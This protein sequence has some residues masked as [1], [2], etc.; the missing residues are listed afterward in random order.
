ERRHQPPRQLPLHQKPG[1]GEGIAE[2]DQTS[3]QAMEKFPKINGFELAQG[4]PEMKDPV[5]GYFFVLSEFGGPIGSRERRKDADNRLPFG[6]RQTGQRQPSDAANNHQK[7]NRGAAGEEPERD[8][9]TPVLS[10]RV[11][12]SR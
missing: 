6:D 10:C 1:E 9:A 2:G 12:D 4:H 11:A 3:E 8:R 5:F 7:K